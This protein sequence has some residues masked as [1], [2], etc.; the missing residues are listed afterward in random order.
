MTIAGVVLAAGSS[1]RLGQPK[2]LV[3]CN[4]EPLLRAIA[5]KV[6]LATDATCVVLGASKGDIRPSLRGL[7]IDVVECASWR[8]GMAAS[9]RAGL[10]WASSGNHEAIVICA[11]DQPALDSSHVAT[12]IAVHH[13]TR[14]I[15]A[16]GYAGTAGV[17]AL[18]PRAWFPRLA[19]LEGDRGARLLLD[20]ATV[21]DWPPGALDLDTPD[22]LDAYLMR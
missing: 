10:G 9:L 20:E 18:F 12:L 6:R 13:A 1:S 19:E 16:S 5:R 3:P 17:P 22:A 2:Q 11:C 8:E 15:V 14:S 7:D 4:G 21:V